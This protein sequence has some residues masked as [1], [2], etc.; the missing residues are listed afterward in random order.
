MGRLEERVEERA[1][2][3]ALWGAG[4][5]EAG[6]GAEG[7]HFHRVWTVCELLIQA[8]VVGGKSWF[9]RDMCQA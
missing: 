3:A 8:H 2:H 6:G 5:E 9:D 7:A 1:Q 4:A